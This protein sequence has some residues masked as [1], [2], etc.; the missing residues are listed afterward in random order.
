MRSSV[1]IGLVSTSLALLACEALLSVFH[2]QLFRRPDVWQHDPEL[3]WR[4]IPKA[5][6]LL[7]KP[8]FEVEYSINSDG[9]RDRDYARNK[10]HG[11][12]RVLLFGD[13]FAEG[14]GVDLSETVGKQLERL[15]RAASPDVIF[16]VINFG[17]AGYGTDQELLFFD[18]LGRHYDPDLV[19][20]L[21]YPNDLLNNSSKMGIGTERGPK[22]Y[23]TLGANGQLVLKGVPVRKSGFGSRESASGWDKVAKY[24]NENW[25]LYVLIRKLRA[26]TAP[27]DQIQAFYESLYGE[28]SS[29]GSEKMW[30]LTARLLHNFRMRVGRAGADM[31][32][33]YVPSIIQIQDE[34]WKAKRELHS[35]VG[36]FDLRKPNRLIAA[37]AERY[38]ISLLD[39][40]PAFQKSATALYYEES[41]WTPEGHRLAARAIGDFLLNG[42]FARGTNPESSR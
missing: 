1:L 33:V 36:S 30:R 21:F 23:F 26:P 24:L 13:S 40:Y 17:M 16:E 20:L 8:E 27:R 18:R 37:V 2:P 42:S 7:A 39:L 15:L 3:G 10:A 22:P 29:R 32:V 11:S 9:L 4:H 12:R 5:K 34:D 14:W 35:L 19:I 6:G 41:H 31:L 25:H 38:R 28:D